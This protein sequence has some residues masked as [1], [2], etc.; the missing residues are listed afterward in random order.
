MIYRLSR[1]IET[2]LKARKWPVLVEYETRTKRIGRYSMAVAFERD[3]QGGDENDPP[4]GSH[5]NPRVMFTRRLGVR[6]EIFAKSSVSGARSNE[7]QHE[8]DDLVDAVLTALYDWTT[9]AKAGAIEWIEA[10]YLADEE[11]D[12]A[13]R[14]SGAVY[15][16]RFRI[17]R[18]VSRKDYGGGAA[19]T[20]T[21]AKVGNASTGARLVKP[22][23]EIEVVPDTEPGD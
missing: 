1:D 19:E 23:G 12:D 22:N 10:R 16:L 5:T 6:V 2:N 9:A 14:S 15:L 8:C 3:R 13:E 7:H 4:V 11:I 20:A 21:L 18:G 17:R